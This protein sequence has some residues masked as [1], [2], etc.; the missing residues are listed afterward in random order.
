M[1]P[2]HGL[3]NTSDIIINKSEWLNEDNYKRSNHQ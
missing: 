2:S 1:K 3:Q